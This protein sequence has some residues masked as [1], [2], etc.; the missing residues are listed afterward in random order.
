MANMIARLGVALGLDTAEFN[1]GIESAGKKLEQFSQAAEKYGKI[2]AVGLVTAGIAAVKY[3]DELAD[4]AEANEVAIGTVLKLSDALANSGGKADNAGKMLS[5][6]AKFIDEAAGGSEQAQKTAKELGVSLQDL[7]KLSQEELLNKLVANLAQVE[8]PITRNA[9]AMEIFSKA[10]KGVDMVGFAEK[11]AEANPLIEEQEKAIKAAAD[12]YDLMAQTSRDV[13]LVLAT[14]LGPILKNTVDYF[15][16]LSD[17]GVSL[18]GIFKTVFQT[19]AVLGS[20]IGWFFK[21]IFNE[22]G[23]TYDNAVILI[24]K[25]KDAA[26]KANEEYNASVKLSRQNLDFY[27]GQV[28]GVSMGR[29]AYDDRFDNKSTSSSGL[30]GGRK[31]TDSGEKERKRLAEAAAKEAKRLAEE[32]ERARLKVI[33][34]L[35]RDAQKYAKILFEIEGQEVAAYTSAAKRVELEQRQLEIKNQLLLI[36]QETFGMRSEDAQ[37]ARELYISEQKRLDIIQEIN[38]NNLLD[39]D[40]KQ[41]L[42]ERQNL[43]AQA[44]EKYLYAQNQAVKAQRQGTLEEGFTK[45]GLKFLRDM[46]TELEQGARAF[47]SLMGNMESAIDRFV[48]T[49]KLNFK[50][51]ARSIIQDIIAMQMKAAAVRFLSSL[52]G[53]G[54]FMNDKG[55]ME[56][57]GSLGFAN[58]GD[59]PVGKVSIV[60]ERGPELFVPRTAGTIIPNHALGGM[61][62]TTNVTNNYINAIDT[63]SF[64]DRLLGSSK[65][66]WAANKYGEKNLATNYGR[67]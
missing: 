64:E 21:T 4:V 27:Q 44:T 2:A 49:G 42:I 13:M 36:D 33:N 25:G 61:G 15:K 22:I 51:L 41:I 48:R 63:K 14:E 29:S 38:R 57:S 5:A 10:A 52:F 31:V 65:A 6:F 8:D 46:P 54:G 55:G 58:G 45:Q 24:T 39:A 20:E 37:L 60:G 59:P 56:V 11:I 3:A 18:S 67:T 9:K 16:T 1:K 32:A 40:A 12:T 35:N 50:D 53:G 26:I 23:H 66:I 34:D 19:V 7:G 28:M 43:L 30:S 17:N 62:G 47:D